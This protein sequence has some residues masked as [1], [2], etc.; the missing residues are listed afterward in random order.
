MIFDPRTEACIAT[1]TPATQAKAR[2]FLQAII[3]SNR[4]PAGWEV[5]IISGTRTY[6]EQAALFAQGRTVPGP[7]VTDAPQG[8]SNHNFGIAFDLGI[9]DPVGKYIDDLPQDEPASWTEKDVSGYYRLLAPIGVALGL[10]WGGDWS[11]IDDEPH[12]E[13]NPW[14]GLSEDQ[15]LAKL[16]AMVAEGET[17]P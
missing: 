13:M 4:L 7:I 6:E 10:V 11:S 1:L 8:Y 15:K 2:A 3:E 14:P 12:Y 5:K 17:I 9:F 16:R